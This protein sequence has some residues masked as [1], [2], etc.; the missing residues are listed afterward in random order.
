MNT[1]N[2]NICLNFRSY[3]DNRDTDISVDINADNVDD[4]KLLKTLNTW[5][6]A[7]ESNL[8]VQDTRNK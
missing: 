1:E 5:L 8:V 3:N 2:N 6:R 7:I 4:K